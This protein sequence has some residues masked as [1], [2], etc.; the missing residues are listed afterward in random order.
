MCLPRISG[1]SHPLPAIRHI[2]ASTALATMT[3]AA[4]A[5]L[6]DGVLSGDPATEVYRVAEIERAGPGSITFLSNPKYEKFLATTG[7]ACVLLPKGHVGRAGLALIHVADPYAAFMT[8][9]RSFA[10][11][12]PTVPPGVHPTAIVA[13]TAVIAPDAAVAAYCVVGER[14]VLESGVVLFPHTVIGED[15]HIG[16]G[17]ALFSHVTV[18]YGCR[19]GARVRI[20]AG[21]VIGADGFGYTENVDG[22][23]DKILQTGIVVIEDDV[24][25][26]ANAAIDR[27]AIGETRIGKGCK[28]DNLVM[29][30]H[31][32]TVGDDSLLVAQSGV[33]GSTRI[34]QH[35][36]L[37]GQAGISGH[38]ELVDGVIVSAQSGVS[39][40]LTKPGL[41]M[42][43]PA[44]EHHIALRAEALQR[45]LPD[46]VQEMRALVD[47]VQEIESLL[48]RD[49]EL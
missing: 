31:N 1:M 29:I 2:R 39:K 3:L 7:A 35:V 44:R 37:A 48:A 6:V 38:I 36:V 34:G 45:Q 12:I 40:S 13:P 5:E 33:S 30:A 14:A 11:P 4:I 46:I 47:R 43:S 27:A 49:T 17:S 19:I 41:Y 8:V 16:V 21:A 26:G 24:E 28:I 25:I 18:Y 42:G 22:H 32:V 20:H 9:H 15:V 10:P 23:Y